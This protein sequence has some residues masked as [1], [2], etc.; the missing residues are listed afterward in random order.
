MLATLNRAARMPV[1]WAVDSAARQWL[2]MVVIA[3]HVDRAA[4]AEAA[5][6]AARA[7]VAEVAATATP[8]LPQ[9]LQLRRQPVPLTGS[10]IRLLVPKVTKELI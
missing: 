7:G 6:R 10:L 2:A 5:T 4:R 8:V 3:G 1:K 9:Q